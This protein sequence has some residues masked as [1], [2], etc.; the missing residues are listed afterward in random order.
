MLSCP[1]LQYDASEQWGGLDEL[2]LLLTAL[3]INEVE[4]QKMSKG[5]I[6][7]EAAAY[8]IQVYTGISMQKYVDIDNICVSLD[9]HT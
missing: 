4:A 6:G 2:Y 9:V 1:A 3:L 5:L 7:Q 8:F